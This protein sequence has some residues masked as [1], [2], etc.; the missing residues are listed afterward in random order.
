MH[1]SF[2]TNR[3]FVAVAIPAE[4]NDYS[5]HHGDDRNKGE[6]KGGGDCKQISHSQRVE[7]HSTSR[8]NLSLPSS[9]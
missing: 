9:C 5:Q 4:Y 3:G 6:T 7:A 1:S 2:R 8:P